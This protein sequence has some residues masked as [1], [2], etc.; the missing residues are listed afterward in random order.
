MQY[1]ITPYTA[2]IEKVIFDQI[3]AARESVYIAVAW[4]TN[5]RIKDKLIEVKPQRPALRIEILVYDNQVM[6][7]NE[8][9]K[10]KIDLGN[11]EFTY[12][13]KKINFRNG[14]LSETKIIFYFYRDQPYLYDFITDDLNENNKLVLEQFIVKLR[15]IVT[16]KDLETLIISR[17]EII[18][19]DYIWISNFL[20][21]ITDKFVESFFADLPILEPTNLFHWPQ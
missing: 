7:F 18:I 14:Q 19:E 15:K 6:L 21:F 2:G 1:T 11:Q 10:F 5:S 20:P 12:P 8:R 3:D 17:P 16:G 4:F 9:I 13:I